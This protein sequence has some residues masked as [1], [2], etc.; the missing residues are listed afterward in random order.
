MAVSIGPELN[1]ENVVEWRTCQMPGNS[2]R[3][4]Q[5]WLAQWKLLL[6]H[7]GDVSVSDQNSTFICAL[8]PEQSRVF[9]HHVETSGL[10]LKDIHDPQWKEIES[11]I[12]RR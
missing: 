2:V 10:G 8:T 11:I 7:A 6:S 12:T 3:E 1:A 9:W 5:E 4:W